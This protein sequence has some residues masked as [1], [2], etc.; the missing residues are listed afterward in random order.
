M[1]CKE[2]SWEKHS[3]KYGTELCCERRGYSDNIFG[4]V[5]YETRDVIPETWGKQQSMLFKRGEYED[6]MEEYKEAV[7][8][9]MVEEGCDP[10]CLEENLTED[11][12]IETVAE[13]CGCSEYMLRYNKA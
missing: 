4:C 10:E 13:M 12:D 11:A 9:S 5:L 7:L 3:I 6:D 1:F 8:I 2:A